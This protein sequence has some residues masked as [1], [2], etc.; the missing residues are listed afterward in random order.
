MPKNIWQDSDEYMLEPITEII[1]AKVGKTLKVKLP[2]SYLDL[3]AQQNGGSI[4]YDSYPTDVP[5]SWV[6][7]H[8]HINHIGGIGKK[9]GVLESDYFKFQVPVHETIFSMAL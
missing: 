3:L 4:I 5:T 7:D 9:D 6:N 8:I 1:V 2:E